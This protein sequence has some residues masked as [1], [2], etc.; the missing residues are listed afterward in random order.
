MTVAAAHDTCFKHP[1]CDR[2]PSFQASLSA[3]DGPVRVMLDANL[4]ATHL[5]DVVQM[6]AR[7]AREHGFTGGH[8]TVSIIDP[9]PPPRLPAQQ[10]W[11]RSSVGFAFGSIALTG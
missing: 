6:L 2:T 3:D 8:V 10:L 11:H 4:C 1:R 9:P 5:G 7:K